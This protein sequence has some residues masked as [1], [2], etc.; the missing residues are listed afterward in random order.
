MKSVLY[1]EDDDSLYTDVSKLTFGKTINII[2]KFLAFCVHIYIYILTCFI[3]RYSIKYLSSPLGPDSL[4][5]TVSAVGGVIGVL[6][7]AMV[8]ITGATIACVCGCL[9]TDY[10]WKGRDALTRTYP[11]L[12]SES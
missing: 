8:C 11:T 4:T 5:V 12:R 9:G 1:I 2:Y 3:K 7:I 6:V 10:C